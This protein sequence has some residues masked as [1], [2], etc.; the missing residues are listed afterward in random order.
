MSTR[1]VETPGQ[2]AVLTAHGRAIVTG[3]ADERRASWREQW[4]TL[5]LFREIHDVFGRQPDRT[6]DCEF[7]LETIVTRMPYENYEK[8]FNTWGHFGA[9]F[10]YD[11][12][13][14]KTMLL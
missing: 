7:V 4:L 2:Q 8:M 6:I 12:P 1:Y 13:T 11:E 3:A 10:A 5:R 14:Q 9:L